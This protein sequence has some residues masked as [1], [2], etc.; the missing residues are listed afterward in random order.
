VLD[1]VFSKEDK[2]MIEAQARNMKGADFWSLKPVLLAGD[3][4]AVHARRILAK[5]IA[6]ESEQAGLT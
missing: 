4:A 3:A 2:P 6:A 5:R 1:E